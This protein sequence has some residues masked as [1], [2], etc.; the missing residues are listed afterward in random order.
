MYLFTRVALYRARIF[1]TYVLLLS[2]V[3]VLFLG[4]F[5][6]RD[7]RMGA[8]NICMK[9]ITQGS[10]KYKRNF[11]IRIRISPSQQRLARHCASIPLISDLLSV[12]IKTTMAIRNYAL[13]LFFVVGIAAI[14]SLPQKS[15][16]SSNFQQ[17]QLFH[18]ARFL[19]FLK[20]PF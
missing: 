17:S 19:N 20:V 4:I 5:I 11:P 13:I 16:V 9:F 6:L 10:I 7:I 8:K 1:S 14:Y 18:L 3:I 2:F 15:N 12:E